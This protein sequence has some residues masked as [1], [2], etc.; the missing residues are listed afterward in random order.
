MAFR[1]DALGGLVSP[2]SVLLVPPAGG[3]CSGPA[4][5]AASF[6][7]SLHLQHAQEVAL[8]CYSGSFCP[9]FHMNYFCDSSA[10]P[11]LM[12]GNMSK[13]FIRVLLLTRFCFADKIIKCYLKCFLLACSES[14]H[15]EKSVKRKGA[16]LHLCKLIIFE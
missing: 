12:L 15:S 11:A 3:E 5:P 16:E 8:T 1:S 6:P 14:K 10:E 13:Y 4:A 9:K 2:V 7:S